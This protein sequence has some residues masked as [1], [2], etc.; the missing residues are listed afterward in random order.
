MERIIINPGVK[1]S[2]Y[3]HLHTDLEITYRRKGTFG[4]FERRKLMLKVALKGT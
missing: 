3:V 1:V 4:F 2:F